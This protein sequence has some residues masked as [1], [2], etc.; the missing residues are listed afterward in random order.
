MD[1]PPELAPADH[2]AD[3][4]PV[5]Q[6]DR[7][8]TTSTS[9]SGGS[10][11]SVETASGAVPAICQDATITIH[12]YDDPGSRPAAEAIT[13]PGRGYDFGRTIGRGGLAQ[14]NVA[15]QRSFRREVAIKTLRHDKSHQLPQ[16]IAEA[17]MAALLQHPNIL[18]IY[19]LIESDE[20][21]LQI[22]MKR[23]R[24]QTW[25]ELLVQD[26]A[27][28]RHL[29]PEYIRNHI[30]ILADVCQAVASAHD[31]GILHRDIKPSNV[32]VGDYGEV[33]LMDWGC[34]AV[35]L[36]R[37]GL[38]GLPRVADLPH[39]IGT[40]C[41]LAP[42]QAR[43]E[44]DRMGPAT[45]VYLLGACLF[46]ILTG[47]PPHP[48]E[49]LPGAI[50]AA[51]ENRLITCLPPSDD[52]WDWPQ[53][54][55]ELALRCLR[56]DPAERPRNVYAFVQELQTFQTRHE[57][58]LLMR[59]AQTQVD[60]AQREPAAA[61][62]HLRKAIG[63]AEEATH[64]WPEHPAC[65]DLLFTTW[66]AAAR[67][68]MG[69][70]DYS[71]AEGQALTAADL[72]TSPGQ[73][74]LAKRVHAD[75]VQHQ[76]QIQ[77]RQRLVGTLRTTIRLLTIALVC[78]L[79]ALA[80]LTLV[81]HQTMTSTRRSLRL[82]ESRTDTYRQQMLVNLRRLRW[83]QYANSLQ[84]A[85]LAWGRGATSEARMALERTPPSMRD[86]AWGWLWLGSHDAAAARHELRLGT[87]PRIAWHPRLPWLA[88]GDEDGALRLM[89][90]TNGRWHD[91][92]PPVELAAPVTALVWDQDGE[93]LLAGLA[94]GEVL[95][96]SREG[97]IR[98]REPLAAGAVTALRAGLV[99][100]SFHF[101]D[102][103]G[104]VQH[105]HLVDRSQVSPPLVLDT[106]ATTL[107]SDRDHRL[108]MGT[109][110][111]LLIANGT[112][113]SA[114]YRDPLGAAPV[115]A[116]GLG[117]ND[118]IL[119]IAREAQ[120]LSV[121]S[122]DSDHRPRPEQR[123]AGHPGCHR[124]AWN[125]TDGS[126]ASG[127]DDGTVRLWRVDLDSPELLITDHAAPISGLGF[128]ADGR[129]LASADTTGRLFIRQ[130]AD[131]LPADQAG[132]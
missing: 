119:A 120:D 82:E 41:Y 3:G 28:R 10:R 4:D 128:S 83:E 1:G 86:W 90:M 115:T 98:W 117:A 50:T 29:R 65:H 106:P 109:A 96:F 17:R 104:K 32:M 8:V 129:C 100:G 132:P 42:E 70:K 48:G 9:V 33:L 24:G 60:L 59:M 68:A 58:R 99:G 37:P 40:P 79:I 114:I 62:D 43:V 31:H 6:V 30:A 2:G 63:F 47:Q 85:L 113:L 71:A 123:L 74:Y 20:G 21:S 92:V 44:V 19:D 18:P 34:A 80:I 54:L 127:G 110:A 7:A 102:T 26:A 15:V 12:A 77:V 52:R 16:F 78:G 97:A 93:D 23:V 27:E 107:V 130:M 64:K 126:L 75:A 95:Q 108:V 36:D 125:R 72:A 53:E 121:I 118:S 51:K 73:R 11:A 124:L 49:D 116:I 94:T 38:D 46:E 81:I 22:V 55:H 61:G 69:V 103:T 105:R 67:H 13:A 66:L 131:P 91:A 112:D 35:Y 111:G 122:I 87:A 39:V 89:T 45:D 57:A 84:S 5:T 76:N 14:V 25:A 101:A 56:T 88:A